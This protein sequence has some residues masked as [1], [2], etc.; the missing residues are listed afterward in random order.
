MNINETYLKFLAKVNK[1]FTNDNIAVDKGRFVLHFNEAQRKYVNWVFSN[2]NSSIVRDIQQLLVRN[3]ELEKAVSHDDLDSF[4]LPKDFFK[5]VNVRVK[6]KSGSC[7]R[8]LDVAH[9]VKSED[10][11][12]LYNDEFNEPSLKYSETFY[13][14]GGN[15]I[16]VYKKGFDISDVFLTYYRFPIPVD[17]EGYIKIDGS[18]SSNIDSEF[19]DETVDKILDICVKDFG[20]NT[21]NL[22]RH[23]VDARQVISTV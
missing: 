13:T 2:N 22:N 6:G 9:E 7:H 15:K 1:N 23:Q 14:F 10:V 12:E 19:D 11:H 3:K 16:E 21:E 8:Y 5:H 18:M 4:T 20:V 17:I